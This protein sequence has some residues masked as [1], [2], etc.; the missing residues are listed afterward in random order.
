MNGIEH[1][2]KKSGRHDEEILETG[3]LVIF[4]SPYS[5]DDTHG[6]QN[7][8]AEKGK[9]Q[10]PD[11]GMINYYKKRKIEL[12]ANCDKI[13]LSDIK[14]FKDGGVNVGLWTV[15]DTERVADYIAQKVDYITTNT[16]FW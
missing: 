12:D 4:V 2:R 9:E 8:G 3:K 10:N 1:T 14:A 15:D 5:G 16:K 13:S 11:Q 6:A 7:R